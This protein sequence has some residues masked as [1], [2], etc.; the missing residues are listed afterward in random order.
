MQVHPTDVRFLDTLFCLKRNFNKWY[1]CPSSY[2]DEL[3]FEGSRQVEGGRLDVE[4]G[5]WEVE[6]G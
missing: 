5:R 4:G 2:K 1:E 6:V 3:E